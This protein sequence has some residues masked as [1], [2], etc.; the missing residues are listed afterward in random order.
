V[1]GAYNN[2]VIDSSHNLVRGQSISSIIRHRTPGLFSEI[3]MNEFSHLH[4]LYYA[5]MSPLTSTF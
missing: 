1:P 5:P 2:H 4:D 3:D